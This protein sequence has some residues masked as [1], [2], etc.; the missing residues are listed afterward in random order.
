MSELTVSVGIPTVNRNEVLFRCLDSLSKQTYSAFE[1]IIINAGEYADLKRTVDKF[2]NLNIKIFPQLGQ[3]VVEARN[4]CWIHSKADIVCIIDDDLVL[5]PDWLKTIRDTFLSDNN[6]GG[7]SGPTII[8]EDG[9]KNRDL[10]LFIG[11]FEK[12][13]N[14][15]M[16]LVGKIYIN[17]ILENKVREIGKILK[18]GAFT[19]GSN[20]PDCLK[21]THPLEVDYL[22]ACHMCFR[23]DLLHKLNGFDNVY[24]GTAEGHEP[25]LSFRV[26]KL[27]YR[28]LFNPRAVTEHRISRGGFLKTRT[29]AYERSR[30]FILFYFKNLKPDTWD[31][32]FRFSVN[33][34]FINGYWC[35]K[36]LESKNPDWL[37]GLWGSACELT[38]NI[39]F[40]SLN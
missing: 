10:T 28:L 34:A 15:L 18:S 12:S 31:K 5:S 27:G 29:R 2:N 13:G 11:K 9:Q 16:R 1:I 20:F 33:L 39:L 36:F 30:N 40:G 14:M 8:P 3:G 4:L 23:R 37:T 7:V 38:N 21:L 6:I 32:L 17:V 19:L 25:D 35:Y 26:R 24:I 22:E